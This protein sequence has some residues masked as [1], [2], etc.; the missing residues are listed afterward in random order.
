MLLHVIIHLWSCIKATVAPYS[1]AVLYYI[2]GIKPM[3]LFLRNRINYYTFT[4]HSRLTYR[5][6]ICVYY[7]WIHCDGRET[8]IY[9]NSR[10]EHFVEKTRVQ[11]WHVW[12]YQCKSNHLWK[13]THQVGIASLTGNTFMIIKYIIFN[14]KPLTSDLICLYHSIYYT[15][16]RTIEGHLQ[17][18][19]DTIY[20]QSYLLWTSFQYF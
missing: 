12:P 15:P 4:S 19:T 10:C 13:N 14:I 11:F 7:T 1:I 18:Q 2:N 9:L 5:R 16:K 20:H 8:I 3:I 17:I 6:T